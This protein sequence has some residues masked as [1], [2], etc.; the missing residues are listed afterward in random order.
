MFDEVSIR[1]KAVS[2]SDVW[3]KKFR[4]LPTKEVGGTKPRD[5]A[6]YEKNDIAGRYG[7]MPGNNQEIS[8]H[9]LMTKEQRTELMK[10]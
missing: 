10:L 8:S 1:E 6:D 4:H 3:P 5:E 7:E 9:N 2:I